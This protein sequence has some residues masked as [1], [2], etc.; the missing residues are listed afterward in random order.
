VAAHLAAWSQ[1]GGGKGAGR[2]QVVE[3]PSGRTYRERSGRPAA[4]KTD[5]G[6]AVAI[7]RITVRE[8]GLP[9]VRLAVAAHR[10]GLDEDVPQER[11]GL[12]VIGS[13]SR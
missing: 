12:D 5:P 9:Q 2:V 1:Q 3:V 6:D 4:G 8:P 10:V 11:R 13:L 7:A